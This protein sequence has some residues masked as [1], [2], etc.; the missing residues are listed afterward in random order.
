MTPILGLFVA[1]WASLAVATVPGTTGAAHQSR[2]GARATPVHPAGPFVPAAHQGASG[3]LTLEVAQLAAGA[4]PPGGRPVADDSQVRAAGGTV[5]RTL[6]AHLG[7]VVDVK[8]L[9][10]VGDGVAD[11]TAAIQAAIRLASRAA[12]DPID[13]AQG[14]G[15]TVFI[16]RGVYKVTAQL[17]WT[18][19]GITLAGEGAAASAIKVA[20]TKD[21]TTT[22]AIK[23]GDGSGAG[24]R[25]HLRDLSIFTDTN[26][27]AGKVRDFVHI[28]GSSW[29][30]LTNVVMRNP[31]RYGLRIG[32]TLHGTVT[33][34]RV[35]WAGDS[36]VC[37][38]NAS[39]GTPQTSTDFYHL[40]TGYNW[41]H[42]IHLRASHTVHLFSPVIE[43][44]G[45][46]GDP[47]VGNGIRLGDGA[48]NLDAMVSMW[49]AYFES[50]RGWDIL[51]GVGL[52]SAQH[53]V[54]MY[55][56]FAT[57]SGNE[58]GHVKSPG[59]GFFHGSRSAGNFD[60]AYLADY[61]ST[62]NHKPYSLDSTC[63]VSIR[64][65]QG[66]LASVNGANAPVIRDGNGL[67][68][69]YAGGIVEWYD[70]NGN[71]AI[72]GR[73][74]LR[75]GG[76]G[77][78]AAAIRLQRDGSHPTSG[79]YLEGDIVLGYATVDRNAAAWQNVQAGSPGS[80]S[81]IVVP[82]R[83]SADRGD[84]SV[85]LTTDGDRKV[86]RFA[87]ALTAHR[88]VTLSTARAVNGNA[89]RIVRTGLGPFTL[90]VGGL[91]TIPSGTAAWVDVAFDGAAWRLTGFGPL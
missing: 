53:L 72:R 66:G 21:P 75:V 32:G 78:G 73:H 74:A 48:L 39:D 55:G 63:K 64:G 37:I 17:A 47:A 4:A 36:G 59:Y 42:G 57:T 13:H 68:D 26:F 90:D 81:A 33:N 19:D 82:D 89:F 85:T 51:S 88:K 56:G 29:P 76:T 60:G 30:K 46:S 71:Y 22:D 41:K 43:Y 16:P 28:D 77:V 1:G 14:G 11:D 50:N 15:G 20:I 3:Q 31:G 83:V 86:Q 45:R 87:T 58:P 23:I 12:I 34:L 25:V 70:D 18:A 24:R 69:D 35:A 61:F 8:N 5:W 38:E 7:E 40:Y 79:A 84:A 2:D 54:S 80:F 6:S 49:G 27:G 62:S 10:A 52:A 9:G 65:N 91:K 67:L 44:N